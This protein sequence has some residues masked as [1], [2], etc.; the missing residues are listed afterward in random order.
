MKRPKG[1]RFEELKVGTGDCISARTVGD[2]K[3]FFKNR[4]LFLE[5]LYIVP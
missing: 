3:L 2:V 5:N 4:F 1:H